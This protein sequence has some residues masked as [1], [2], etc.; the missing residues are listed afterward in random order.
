RS[1]FPCMSK[2]LAPTRGFEKKLRVRRARAEKPTHALSCCYEYARM[3]RLDDGG[4][5]I[6]LMIRVPRLR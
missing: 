3:L 2:A 6:L 5:W 1:G 4:R